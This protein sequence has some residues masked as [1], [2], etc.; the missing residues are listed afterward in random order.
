MKMTH[1]NLV[2]SLALQ[3]R[4]LTKLRSEANKIGMLKLAQ[5]SGLGV[6]S[7]YKSLD[8]EMEKFGNPR[9]STVILIAQ[10]LDIDLFNV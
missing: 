9:L 6:N 8:V 10:A 3:K 7:L 1:R 5:L 4:I 2:I